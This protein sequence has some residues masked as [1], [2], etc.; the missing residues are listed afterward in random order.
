MYV[1]TASLVPYPT[2]EP[3]SDPSDSAV[4]ALLKALP[5]L[6]A[7]PQNSSDASPIEHR[8]GGYPVPFKKR[9]SYSLNDHQRSEQRTMEP[10]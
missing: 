3:V 10:V 2:S 7:S 8:K 1:Q 9:L 5:S 4:R 6:C